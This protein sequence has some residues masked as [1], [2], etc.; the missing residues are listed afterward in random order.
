MNISEPVSFPW[1]YKSFDIEQI[2][3]DYPPPPD[4]FGGVFRASRDEL[5]ALQERRFLKTMKRGWEIPS[6][7]TFKARMLVRHGVIVVRKERRQAAGRSAGSLPA[8]DPRRSAK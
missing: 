6:H 4:F 3:R 1:Y 8:E 7:H 2:W 5:R